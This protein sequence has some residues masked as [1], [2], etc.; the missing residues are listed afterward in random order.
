MSTKQAITFGE[1]FPKAEPEIDRE[2][3]TAGLLLKITGIV[4][5]TK[6]R[7]GKIAKINAI[8]DD[9][10]RKYRTT[11]ETVV[12]QCQEIMERVPG[13]YN[14]TKDVIVYVNTRNNAEGQPYLFFSE[15]PEE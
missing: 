5:D 6:T 8:V 9:E 3:L 2:Q 10:E 1:L 12:R 14:L 11:S 15:P 13:G 4:I 7:Y